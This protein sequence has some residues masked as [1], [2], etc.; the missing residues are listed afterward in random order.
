MYCRGLLEVL[1]RH[2]PE[3][4]EENNETRSHDDRYPDQGSNQIPS[5]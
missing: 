2:L 5:K 1:S 4:T 3:G